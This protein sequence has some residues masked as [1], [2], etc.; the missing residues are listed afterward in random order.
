MRKHK[1]TITKWRQNPWIK[2]TKSGQERKKERKEGRK[3]ERKKEVT[4]SWKMKGKLPSLDPPTRFYFLAGSP[5]YLLFFF[6]T[7]IIVVYLDSFNLDW[8]PSR[9]VPMYF[10]LGTHCGG[11]RCALPPAPPHP[12]LFFNRLPLLPTLFRFYSYVFPFV[13]FFILPFRSFLTIFTTIVLICF[14]WSLFVFFDP[15][16]LFFWS[17]FVFFD[18]LAT[19]AIV[20][21]WL[22]HPVVFRRLRQGCPSPQTCPTSAVETCSWG[23]EVLGFGGFPGGS[24]EWSLFSKGAR[25][26]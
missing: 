16:I 6:F 7:S 8:Y 14:F 26:T 20:I 17:L 18:P 22:Y 1:E 3:K 9:L 5:C 4:F 23:Q 10:F 11:R 19:K 15:S 13:F 12:L 2:K 21:P 25:I 24:V